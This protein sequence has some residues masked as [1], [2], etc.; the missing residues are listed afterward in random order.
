MVEMEKLTKKT[1]RGHY[2]K[3]GEMMLACIN[4]EVPFEK[5]AGTDKERLIDLFRADPLLNQFSLKVFDLSYPFN[6]RIKGGPKCLADNCCMLK[7]WLIYEVIGAEPDFEDE[8][9]D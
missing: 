3:F 5:F 8:N 7:H 6:R 9:E 4:L 1:S 2:E